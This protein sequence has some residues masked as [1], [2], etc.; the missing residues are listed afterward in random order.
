MNS[1]D[2]L[3]Q[4]H[5]NLRQYLT[6][7]MA[8]LDAT[9]EVQASW[10]PVLTDAINDM[11]QVEVQLKALNDAVKL[12][13]EAQLE[14]TFLVTKTISSKEV[15]DNMDDWKDAVTTEFK[16]L[17]QVKKAVEAVDK[18]ELHRRAAEENL[19]LEILPAK[20]VYTRKSGSGAFRARAVV[21]GNYAQDRHAESVYAG[22]IDAAQI[23]AMAQ[24]AGA[25]NWKAAG[26]DIRVAFLNAPR[27]KDRKLVAM[28]IPLI[29]KKLQLCAPGEDYWII[30]LAMYG[31]TTSPKDWGDHRDE[32][33][34]KF[35]WTRCVEGQQRNGRFQATQDQHLWRMVE[36]D[37]DSNLYWVGLMG[38][39][40]DDVLLM[41]EPTAIQ[42]SFAAIEA[43]WTTS[44][45]DWCEESKPLKFLGFEIKSDEMGN[46]FR[47]GQEMYLQELLKTWEISTG[48]AYP[49]FRI[50]EEDYEVSPEDIDPQDVKTAQ[51]LCG[52]LLRLA[53]R[54]R[55]DLSY[56]VSMMSRLMTRNPKRSVEIG[57]A[58]LHYLWSNRDGLHVPNTILEKWGPNQQLKVQRT[59]TTIEVFADI[60]FGSGA[61]GKSIQGLVVC[62]GGVPVSWM[63]GQQPFVCQS[64]AESE[65]VSYGE[66][67]NAGRATEALMASIYD[68]PL[69]SEMFQRVL[70]GDN[71]AAIGI[72]H[73]TTSTTWRTRHLKIRA[74][75]LREALDGGSQVPGGKWKLNHLRGLDLMADGLTK[76]LQGQ[77]FQR[78]LT[79][80]GMLSKSDHAEGDPGRVG[81]STM[82]LQALLVG[83]VLL[84][85]AEAAAPEDE[86]VSDDWNGVWVGAVLLM[87]VGAVQLSRM[88]VNGVSACLNRLGGDQ[89]VIVVGE[90]ED[91]EP[92]THPSKTC[93]R[94]SSQSGEHGAGAATSGPMETRL[95]ASSQSGTGSAGA[96]MSLTSGQLMKRSLQ[97]GGSA[98]MEQSASTRKRTTTLGNGSGAEAATSSTA[99]VSQKR[100]SR[101]SGSTML[102]GN[103]SAATCSM[104]TKSSGSV[105]E[106]LTSN[107]TVSSAVE[108]APK[109]Q[110]MSSWNRF[111]HSL[112]GR[113]LNSTMMSTLYHEAKKSGEMP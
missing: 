83:S 1:V 55:P 72:A 19:D 38:V 111:Q 13:E 42:Q 62:V 75:Y 91:E 112:R 76:A 108:P 51:A 32:R 92:M 27:R 25:H 49:H 78:F 79:N 66:A 28:E 17:T 113:G 96:A 71:V 26:T 73:G 54:T 34:P 50:S 44:G 65:L 15:W 67:L 60:S 85:C 43:E 104:A 10:L 100:S 64:T 18:Q 47:V 58:L 31:L 6:E 87:A 39:Y 93:L 105:A 97:S 33:L 9:E 110:P 82:A 22:G 70:Y 4:V 61:G 53:T 94:M 23:R 74:S 86:E 109:R 41:G 46:G 16:Q 57:K 8:K 14:E 11:V 12:Q 90:S 29:F 30:R 59:S 52:S 95:K 99:E 84:T 80:I 101:A 36:Y 35:R 69:D 7:E 48:T 81:E 45:L 40:V 77:A 68:V 37:D 3:D 88:C 89:S 20:M 21:C 63:S 98:S 103:G 107:C 2:V 106:D 5:C 24:T 102:S 56:G